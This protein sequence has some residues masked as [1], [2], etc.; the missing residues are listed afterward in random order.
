ML[1]SSQRHLVWLFKHAKFHILKHLFNSFI[2]HK[3]IISC[4]F[5]YSSSHHCVLRQVLPLRFRFISFIH[6]HVQ[7]SRIIRCLRMWLEQISVIAYHP[8]PP[9]C[10]ETLLIGK[11]CHINSMLIELPMINLTLCNAGVFN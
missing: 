11:L 2:Y 6:E 7:I 5:R 4:R 1:C 3:Y 10:D 8:L 9:I